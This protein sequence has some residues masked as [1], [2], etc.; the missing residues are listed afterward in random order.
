MNARSRIP[1]TIA[2]VLL[3]AV[4]VRADDPKPAPPTAT[5]AADSQEAVA[6]AP[7]AAPARKRPVRRALPPEAFTTPTNYVLVVN[8]DGALEAAWLDQQCAFMQKQLQ[9][10]VKS[11]AATG[12][13]GDSPRAFVQG[14]RAR[15]GDNAKIV[16]VVSK[17]AGLSP[18]LASPSEYWTVMDAAWIEK[19]GG[20]DALRDE[21]MGK[22]IFQALGHCVGAGYRLEREAVM[23]HTP[24]PEAMDDCLSRGFHPLNS[25]I[26]DT[27]SR[28][29]GLDAIRLRPRKELV[30]LGILQPLQPIA[31][32]TPAQA[33]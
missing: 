5:P 1:P 8:H 21:R 20:D 19:A 15:H 13:I 17:E 25:Q 29:I 33:E 12:E 27:V 31:P 32:K 6:P 18:L 16:V 11:D 10:A 7:D 30:E 3:F 14:V 22:R 9:V 24:T 2:A 4:A 23:R 28:G 26:F